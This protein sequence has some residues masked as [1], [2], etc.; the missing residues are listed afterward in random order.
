VNWHHD[1]LLLF[2]EPYPTRHPVPERFRVGDVNTRELMGLTGSQIDGTV[3]AHELGHALL[4]LEAG[5]H[6]PQVSIV[7]D[8]HRAGHAAATRTGVA[9]EGWLQAVGVAGGERAEDRWL[10]EATLWTRERAAVVELGAC[11]DRTWLLKHSSPRFAFG[12]DDGPDFA[13]MHDAADEAL[14]RVW[15]RLMTVLPVL[16]R[17]RVMTGEQLAACVGL[18]FPQALVGR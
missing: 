3:A 6:V 16:I 15:G 11:N 18:P 9:N 7:F 12:T 8:G 13:L 10:R 17:R 14:D 4:W 2:G 1:G 5:L